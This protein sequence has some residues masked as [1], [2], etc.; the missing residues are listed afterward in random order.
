MNARKHIYCEKAAAASVTGAKKVLAAGA[1]ADP[2][3]SIVFGFQQRYSPEYLKAKSLIA[4]GRIGDVKL[5]SS[6]WILANMLS[7]PFERLL[8][9]EEEKVRRWEFYKETSGCP[10]VEQDCH[11]IDI[12]NWFA[13]AHPIKAVGTGG[14]RY[15][16][17]WGNWTSDH[18][19]ITYMYPNGVEGHL[20]SVKERHA[21]HYRD[22]REMI[23]GSTGVIETARTYYKVFGEGK[24]YDAKSD[25]DLRDRSLLEH[26][27]S[28]HE[29][30]IDAV[31][32]FFT[33]ITSNKP[34]HDTE[35][36]VNS[37]LTSLLGRMAYETGRAANWEELLSSD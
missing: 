25:D 2:T 36:A 26:R 27:N 32:A 10:I 24:G 31:E 13:G 12:M 11:G 28:K 6:Y 1:V 9:P 19:Y 14:L 16:L 21:V 5:M 23:W 37:T 29:I 15:P 4:E 7:G 20:I 33:S 18:H 35:T 34:I 17:C 22:V 3:R 8:P 30:T